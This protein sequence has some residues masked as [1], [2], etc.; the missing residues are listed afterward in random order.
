MKTG[1]LTPQAYIKGASLIRYSNEMGNETVGIDLKEILKHPGSSSDLIL[2]PGDHIKIPK[3]LQTV[4]IIGNVQNQI[5]ATFVPGKT[6]KYYINQTGG[7]KERTRKSKN[8]INYS[9]WFRITIQY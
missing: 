3:K 2:M 7:Y 4:K 1:G 6:L 5:S 9:W 8:W